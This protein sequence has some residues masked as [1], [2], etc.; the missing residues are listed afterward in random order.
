MVQNNICR[1]DIREFQVAAHF[2]PVDDLFEI[3]CREILAEDHLDR[4]PDQ[5]ARDRF[6][7]FQ[8]ALIFQFQFAGDRRKRGV[9][10][11][12]ADVAV[13]AAADD[14]R[15]LVQAV[16]HQLA[17]ALRFQEPH[18]SRSPMRSRSFT[19]G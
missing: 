9:D 17:V 2:K 5:I 15:R 3:G 10:V 7:A 12:H 1:I 8:L 13:L 14:D 11:G 19:R 4:L 6:R 16:R 18:A